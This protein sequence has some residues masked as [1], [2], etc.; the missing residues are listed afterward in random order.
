MNKAEKTGRKKQ[1]SGLFQ[2]Q[3]RMDL[4]SWT[5]TMEGKGK[6]LRIPTAKVEFIEFGEWLYRITNVNRRNE[7]VLGCLDGSVG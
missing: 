7:D 5:M 1:K 4:G 3:K 2:Q 6:A